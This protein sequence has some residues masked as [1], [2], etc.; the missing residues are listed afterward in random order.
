MELLEKGDVQSGAF[1]GNVPAK[2]RG[3]LLNSDS[4]RFANLGDDVAEALA[5]LSTGVQ[6]VSKIN[7][8]R[9]RKA[10]LSQAHN[11]QVERVK[12]ATNQFAKLA[13]ET[14][15]ENYLIEKNG[16]QPRALS[17]K[18]LSQYNK[19]VNQIPDKPQGSEEG[20]TFTDPKTG[21]R[22]TVNGPIMRFAG[23][24]GEKNG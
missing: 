23:F 4:D 15:I 16:G 14:D 3:T 7:F 20:Q 2:L 10:N 8:N 18:V 19:L 9:E 5:G 21:A 13:L 24:K 1:A 17:T 11:T 12:D 22:W 6:T